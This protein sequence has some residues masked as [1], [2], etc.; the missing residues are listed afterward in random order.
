MT[1]SRAGRDHSAFTT[2]RPYTDSFREQIGAADAA[3]EL[4]PA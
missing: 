3:A 4:Y 2:C 1:K